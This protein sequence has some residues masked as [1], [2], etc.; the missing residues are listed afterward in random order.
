MAPPPPI[1]KKP[2]LAGQMTIISA[3]NSTLS[4]ARPRLT[5]RLGPKPKES[6]RSK[7]VLS[8]RLAGGPNK[9]RVLQ[10]FAAFRLSGQEGGGSQET[11]RLRVRRFGRML[12]I[13]I[14]KRRRKMLIISH[15]VDMTIPEN[16]S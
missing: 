2:L 14:Y 15:V 9:Q 1:P 6:T 5:P 8:R 10:L 16:T 3:N 13:R 12:E 11:G 4:V 7:T